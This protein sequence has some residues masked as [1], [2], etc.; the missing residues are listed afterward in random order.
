M[1]NKLES[2][3]EQLDNSNEIIK[4]AI[5]SNIRDVNI[6]NVKLSWDDFKSYILSPK[7]KSVDYNIVD[8]SNGEYSHDEIIKKAIST[9]KPNLQYFV[10]GYF[11]ILKRSND[12]LHARTLIV[13]DIDN[14]QGAIEA[15]SNSLKSELGEYD[16]IA[17]STASHRIDKPCIRIVLRCNGEIKSD[18]YKNVVEEFV[19]DLS[20]KNSIDIKAS[21][22]P[23][24]AMYM[25]AIIEVNSQ[26]E[27]AVQYKYEYWTQANT[28]KPVNIANYSAQFVEM[29]LKIA[30]TV[31]SQAINKD[32]HDYNHIEVSTDKVME[33]L[34]SY[35]AE[36]LD[37]HDWLEVAMGLHHNY[38]GSE[39]GYKILDQWSVQDIQGYNKQENRRHW[40]SFKNKQ[41][42]KT[43]ASV[44]KKINDKKK[45]SQKREIIKVIESLK[46]DFDQEN[47]LQPVIGDIVKHFNMI[48]AEYF[49]RKIKGSTKLG[50]SFIRALIN[51]EY[52]KIAIEEVEQAK[53]KTFPID[54]ALPAALFEGYGVEGSLIKT[55][56]SNLKILIKYY[57]ITVRRNLIS[58]EDEIIIPNCSFNEE[59]KDEASFATLTSLCELNNLTKSHHLNAY[60]SSIASENSYNP[61]LDYVLSKPWDGKSRL[62]EIYDTIILEEG[63]SS[64]LAKLLVRK[65]LIS[66]VAAV[67]SEKGVFSK[68]VLLFQSKQSIGK[69]TWFKNMMPKG[70]E[71]YFKD[72]AHLDPT[73]KDSVRTIISHVVVE[74][75][76]IDSTFKRDVA[77][78]KA[79]ISSDK[80]IF[81]IKYGKKDTKFARRTVFC[82]T[83]N[84]KE[85][86]KDR[87]GNVRFW[88][89]S[90]IKLL[91]TDHIDMQQLWIELYEIYK[92]GER[93][94][95]EKDEEDL[96]EESNETFLET[97]PYEEI[98]KKYLKPYSANIKKCPE[99]NK[100]TATEILIEMKE[101]W[102]INVNIDQRATRAIASA[103]HRLGFKREPGN[104][105]RYYIEPNI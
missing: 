51:K 5:G 31:S 95:L 43:F 35:P 103:L 71:Q 48:E 44:I 14:Y 54:K 99:V 34:N 61:I 101:N 18:I 66:M 88:V 13:L 98:I 93:W 10:G 97:C 80:D 30:E 63:F 65:W 72:G 77:R 104:R 67:A 45:V 69:T 4:L 41:K 94:W 42:I 47:E 23:S 46:E 74:L 6:R 81:R 68:G 53:D 26:P 83:V 64:K 86:L 78:L 20:F 24:Q 37:F 58:R 22:T 85:V 11:N 38:Q 33:C 73:D 28:G 32:I 25:P 84:Q 70:L 57:G 59:T 79:F 92:S 90:I 50:L 91:P 1:M 17:Y 60:C 15:L 62:D 3:M 21:T 102:H 7:N 29:P 100:K 19:K 82:G 105:R 36:K 49:I 16:Y 2:E 8:N 76:E 9:I 52:K 56:I 89:I 12:N 40:E 39:E 55:T 87:T 75:G 96:L 27:N